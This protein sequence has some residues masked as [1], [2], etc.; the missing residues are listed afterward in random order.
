MFLAHH[1]FNC[2]L[3]PIIEQISEK[4]KTSGNVNMSTSDV[5]RKAF[6][7]LWLDVCVLRLSQAKKMICEKFKRLI[8]ETS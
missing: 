8:S 4:R 6:K 7:K 1:F 2:A 3:P 5:C